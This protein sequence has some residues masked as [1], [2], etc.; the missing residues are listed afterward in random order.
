VTALL[1]LHGLRAAYGTIEV[2]HGIDLEVPAGGIFAVLGP[3]GAGK[4]TLLRVVAGLHAPSGGSVVLAGRN[5]NGA[6]PDDLARSGLCLVP[7]G[8]G[9][10][11]NLTVSENL[12]LVTHMGTS[13]AA[14]EDRT[15]T[16]FPRLG[17]RRKQI[18]GTLSGGE[19]QMLALAR[20]VSTDPAFLLVDELSMGLAPRIVEGLYALVA[21]LAAEGMTVLAVEQFARTILGIASHAV[22]MATGRVIHSGDPAD[23]AEAL[24]ELY[25][26]AAAK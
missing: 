7:E 25:L 3:N 5:V 1:E 17:D 18:A 15:Y 10:F 26:G 9:I 8:R 19:Q 23:M 4:S 24:S 2:L 13:L 22:V 16:R 6:R 21:E 11:P 14:V 12:R 20:A